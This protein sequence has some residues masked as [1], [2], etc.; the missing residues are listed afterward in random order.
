MPDF[1]VGARVRVSDSSDY[2]G[3]AGSIVSAVSDNVFQVHL[4][5]WQLGRTYIFS[6]R[7]LQFLGLP[8]PA[9]PPPPDPG[10]DTAIAPQR[11]RVTLS[12]GQVA[13]RELTLPVVPAD[14]LLVTVDPRGLPRQFSGPDFAVTGTTL[15]WADPEAGLYALLV[16]GDLLIIE[17]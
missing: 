9:P 5:G 10:S 12:A 11:L 15:S 1:A 2:T 6:T 17:Y 13:S 16:A 3:Y 8:D 7:Q 14:P 4:D